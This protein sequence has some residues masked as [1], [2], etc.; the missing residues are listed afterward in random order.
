[1]ATRAPLQLIA[2][3]IDR[4]PKIR[5]FQAKNDIRIG[6]KRAGSA[7][8]IQGMLRWKVHAATLIDN[9]SLQR[10]RQF[11]EGL[12]SRSRPGGAINENHGSLSTD[13]KSRRF[14]Y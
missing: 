7:G 12:H 13:E 1:D 14:Q 6:D 9:R 3:R 8:L 2:I 4:T 5:E 10:L 11:N